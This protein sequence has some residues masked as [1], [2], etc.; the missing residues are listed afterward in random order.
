[1]QLKATDTLHAT[2]KQTQKLLY[3]PTSLDPHVESDSLTTYLLL[4]RVDALLRANLVSSLEFSTPT[5][6]WILSKGFLPDQLTP[7]VVFNATSPP[8]QQQSRRSL[9]GNIRMLEE[10]D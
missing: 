3:E 4:T 1:M 6:A 5:P 8:L 9:T 2:D 7:S 10:G